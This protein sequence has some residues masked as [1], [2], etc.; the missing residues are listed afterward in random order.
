MKIILKIIL[1]VTLVAES[2]TYATDKKIDIAE[3][4]LFRA[5]TSDNT[6]SAL[7]VGVDP[8]IEL[9]TSDMPL[10]FGVHKLYFEFPKTKEKLAF[11]PRGQL[12][13]SDWSFNIFSPDYR[14]VV[15]LQDHYGPYHIIPISNLQDYLAGKNPQ[16]EIV[17]AS[18]GKVS[19][20]HGEINW[21]SIDTIEFSAWCCGGS[22]TVI[23]KIGE[24]K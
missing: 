22:Y 9:E 21:L 11:N 7:W 3:K 12:F 6:V 13:F 2:S 17:E 4:V 23:H 20:V 5:T 15:L 8:N 18:N 10:T 14:F 1:I 19:A 16:F 24:K